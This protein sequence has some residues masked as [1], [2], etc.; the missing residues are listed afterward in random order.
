[1]DA[2]TQILSG[3][4]S[5]MMVSLFVFLSAAILAFGMMAVVQVR[6]AVRRRA[7]GIG[8]ALPHARPTTRARCA[9]RAASRRNG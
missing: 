8:Q 2:L 1:M 7:A 3:D 9:M 6:L 5:T 4:S